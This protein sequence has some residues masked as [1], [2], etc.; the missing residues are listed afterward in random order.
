MKW[1]LSWC[2]PPPTS[3]EDLTKWKFKNG[4]IVWA[5]HF[6]EARET[7]AQTNTKQFWAFELKPGRWRVQFEAE[8]D[9][10]LFVDVNAETGVE[11]AKNARWMLHMD[12]KEEEL[13]SIT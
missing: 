7:L 6:S 2:H 8:D 1:I 3:R 12:Y 10:R 11:A 13:L 5:S 4:S 9:P